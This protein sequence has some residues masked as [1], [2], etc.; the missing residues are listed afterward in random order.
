M[1]IPELNI[2]AYESWLSMSADMRSVQ[3]ELDR[4]NDTTITLELHRA[5]GRHALQEILDSVDALSDLER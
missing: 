1:P 3:V 2:N 5:I 4:R